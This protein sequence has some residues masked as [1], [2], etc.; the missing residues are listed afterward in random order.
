MIYD[1]ERKVCGIQTSLACEIKECFIS[2]TY[3][4]IKKAN[5]L[6]VCGIMTEKKQIVITKI[7][8]EV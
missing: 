6:D 7:T 1:R 8:K 4:S 5:R 2:E 3:L